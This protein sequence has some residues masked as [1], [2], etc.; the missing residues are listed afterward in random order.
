MAELSAVSVDDE[1]APK[2]FRRCSLIE[3]S[4][5]RQS[6]EDVTHLSLCLCNIPLN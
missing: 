5:S 2:A 6:D 3:P 4:E 1:S